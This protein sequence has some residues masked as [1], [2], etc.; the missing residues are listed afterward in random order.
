MTQPTVEE[1]DVL[2]SWGVQVEDPSLITADLLLSA[3]RDLSMKSSINSM[4]D[5]KLQVKLQGVE[6]KITDLEKRVLTIEQVSPQDFPY[7]RLEA[8]ENKVA[9]V[10][11][12][13]LGVNSYVGKLH[14]VIAAQGEKIIRLTTAYTSSNAQLV[15]ENLRSR[16]LNCRVYGV[17]FP[18]G[19]FELPS[20][21]KLYPAKSKIDGAKYL[22]RAGLYKAFGKSAEDSN[23]PFVQIAHPLPDG[24]PQ[25]GRF[26]RSVKRSILQFTDRNSAYTFWQNQSKFIDEAKKLG[27]SEVSIGSDWN[28][29]SS[30]FLHKFSGDPRVAKVQIIDGNLLCRLTSNPAKALKV[31]NPFCDDLLNAFTDI[32]V[33]DL[34]IQ[35]PDMPCLQD[36]LASAQQFQQR[37]LPTGQ[38]SYS[39]GAQQSSPYQPWHVQVEQCSNRFGMLTSP[40]SSPF[41]A[42]MPANN[43]LGLGFSNRNN[44]FGNTIINLESITQPAKLKAQQPQPSLSSA[45]SPSSGQHSVSTTVTA[46]QLTTTSSSTSQQSTSTLSLQPPLLTSTQPAVSTTTT[47]LPPLPQRQAFVVDTATTATATTA[48]TTLTTSSQS[49]STTILAAPL[50][51]QVLTQLQPSTVLPSHQPNTSASLTE[52]PVRGALSLPIGTNLNSLLRA[53]TLV[54]ASP[55]ADNPLTDDNE[56]ETGTKKKMVRRGRPPKQ[57]ISNKENEA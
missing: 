54:V 57:S 34:S 52:S 47:L 44:A 19:P 26:K 32:N 45:A 25:P 16:R 18:D 14:A 35:V 4:L 11:S 23:L 51:N 48:S 40:T 28:G 39:Q 20:G 41:P 22:W 56:V 53:P 29:P 5:S 9:S 27:L 12:G 8:L 55:E 21:Q 30:S 50:S 2:K 43:N 31:K 24:N 3:K 7:D 36:E 46:T 6:D 38:L 49:Q 1:L 17:S 33:P 37:S 13:L 15:A 10:D 42:T